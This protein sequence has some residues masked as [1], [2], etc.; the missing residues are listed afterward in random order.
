MKKTNLFDTERMF[1]DLYC[2][3]PGQTQKPHAHDGEDKVYYVVEGEGLFRVGN[4]ERSIKAQSVVL[5]P[6]GVE[7]GVTNRSSQRLVVLV[8]MAPKPHH[9]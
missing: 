9:H 3:E 8:F 2:F 6:A 4:E 1:C 7:H 5:A